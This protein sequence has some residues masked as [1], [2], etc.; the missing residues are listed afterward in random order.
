[1]PHARDRDSILGLRR[2][3]SIALVGVVAAVMLASAAV[4]VGRQ[5]RSG[6][7]PTAKANLAYN[8]LQE[9][10]G[11]APVAPDSAAGGRGAVPGSAMRGSLQRDLFRPVWR[12]P[13]PSPPGTTPAAPSGPP[14]L[15]GIFIDGPTREAV[16]AGVRVHEGEYVDGY[17]VM[18]IRP[19]G[20]RLRKG[21]SVVRLT[22]GGHR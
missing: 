6:P 10:L 3:R 21:D 4:P 11:N 12:T 17:R 15:T 1:M 9:Q 13:A 19:N 22:W 18:A 5:R 8:R 20:V 16:L 7:D 14:A 2:P